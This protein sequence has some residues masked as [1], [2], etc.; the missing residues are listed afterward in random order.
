MIKNIELINWKTHKDTT[1]E[2]QKGVNVLVGIMGA[3]KSSVMDAISYAL[4]G[5]FP[6][7]AHK[8]VSLGNVI[9]NRPAEETH[10]EVRLTFDADGSDYRVIRKV[11]AKQGSEARIEK[12]GN[13]LQAQSERVTETIEGILKLD[14]DTFSRAVYAE[15]NG[16]EYFLDLS[17][18][19]RKRSID[20][21]LGLDHFSMA[22]E[23]AT[24]YI[25]SI[26]SMIEGE[27]NALTQIDIKQFKEQMDTLSKEREEIAIR[28]KALADRASELSNRSNEAKLGLESL[29]S[30]M[31][32]K[33]ALMEKK[34]AVSARNAAL[35]DEI[36]KIDALGIVKEAVEKRLK[37]AADK[38]DAEAAELER[39]RKEESE[40]V[41]SLSSLE[42]NIRVLRKRASEKEAL[43]VSIKGV[44]ST[45]L[46]EALGSY[47]ES[48]EELRDSI[49]K[50]R[51]RIAEDEKW[52]E[53]LSK[54]ISTCPLCERE[55]SQEM[56]QNLLENKKAGIKAVEKELGGYIAQSKELEVKIAEAKA[57]ID[58]F[59]L[60]KAKLKDFENVDSDLLKL[61][62]ELKEAES[63]HADVENKYK[64]KLAENEKL[65]E[66]VNNIR[67]EMEKVKR[68]ESYVKEVSGNM[69]VLEEIDGR[70]SKMDVEEKD[71][72]SAQDAFTKI[73]SELS[74]VNSKAESDAEYTKKIDAQIAEKKKQIEDFDRIES[75]IKERRALVANLNKFKAALIDTEAMLRSKLIW[76]VNNLMQSVWSELYP[77]GDYTAIRLT[78]KKD[79]YLLESRI[80]LEGNERW[81]GIDSVASGGERSLACLAMRIAMSMVIVPNLRWI[82]LDEPTH[83]IDSNGIDRLISMLGGNLPGV[84]DQVFIITHDESMKQISKAR[85][86]MLDRDKEVHGSTTASVM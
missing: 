75:R 54:H 3:G 82:I 78:A 30:T 4:F 67:L 2:F 80:V 31:E 12:D 40:A 15:Q 33:R 8:R 86:Y 76:S 69:S 11:S 9:M 48:L 62:K 32:K 45:K 83:N 49:A 16:L 71:I 26:R 22:E 14:Y 5:N 52:I 43:L 29:R 53:E 74:E 23:N 10:A 36:S 66:R 24:S 50:K 25:N 19:E 18:G 57:S 65:K 84:V 13:Y 27:E 7:L 63:R 51:A 44:E 61:S 21:M 73:S 85:V 6:A 64:A 81:I 58:K 46:K 42:T 68:R 59:M 79:D 55:L 35:R 17:K 70:L 34:T 38:A 20:E 41:R 47:N 72:Y 77:Y 28:R 56:R 37:E 39:L 1:I 60:D